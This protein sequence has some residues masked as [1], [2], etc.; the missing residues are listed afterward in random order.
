MES[1]HDFCEMTN[2]F[3]LDA[4]LVMQ[5]I[6]VCYKRREI[7]ALVDVVTIQET[8]TSTRHHYTTNC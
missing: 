2:G 6:G 1:I 3:G 8:H 4:V 5:G 7:R